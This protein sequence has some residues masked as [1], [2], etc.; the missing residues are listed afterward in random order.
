MLVGG[1]GHFVACRDGDILIAYGVSGTNFRTLG[2][3]RDGKRTTFFL[4]LC[5]SC[6]VNHTLV[7]LY[8]SISFR[9]TTDRYLIAAMTEI[10]T[11]N[12]HSCAAKLAEHI[13][14]VSLGT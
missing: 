4:P 2:V 7:V 8:G 1:D 11:D 10:H 14:I 12:V 6:I 3:E 9:L 13:D 5:G